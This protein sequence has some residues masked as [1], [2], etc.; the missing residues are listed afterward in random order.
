[1]KGKRERRIDTSDYQKQGERHY[2]IKDKQNTTR[3]GWRGRN[4]CAKRTKRI[5]GC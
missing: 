5:V 3:G 4:T 1:M 2:I